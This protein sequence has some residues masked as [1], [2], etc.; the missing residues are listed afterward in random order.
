MESWVSPPK[1]G[2]RRAFF[3]AS[4]S[5][6]GFI[7]YYET[8]FRNQAQ[9]LYIIKGGP[10]TGKSRLMW[11][12]VAAGESAGFAAELYF[13]SSDPTSL[14]AVI[15]THADG[16]SVIFLD[17]T[18]PHTMEACAPG[19]NEQLID[20]GA[21]WS[22]DALLAHHDRIAAL[23]E[24][25]S[26]RYTTAYRYLGAA[27]LCEKNIAD[28]IAPA[29]DRAALARL[30][31][32]LVA[33]AMEKTAAAATLPPKCVCTNGLGM[34][35]WA[36]LP[37]FETLA[38]RTC[39]L[40]SCHGV[41]YA[42]L[43]ALL[44]EGRAKGARMT[45]SC[46]PVYPAYIDGIYFEDS[47]VAFLVDAPQDGT[48]ATEPEAAEQYRRL[49]KLR[50]LIKPA[51]IRGGRSALRAAKRQ[52]DAL[53]SAAEQALLHAATPHF[54]LE[55]IYSGA[56]DFDAKETRSRALAHEVFG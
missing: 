49:V 18:A 23:M 48:D 5:E 55:E 32:R 8:L 44:A 25:K 19:V 17:G 16:R 53:V 28:A 11:D 22:R 38:K 29:L 31:R 30:A 27:G 36:H 9:L 50:R 21:F 10:G 14:D 34:K 47:R 3:A 56:M 20:L 4:N 51:L 52:R 1:Q 24:E 13:C 33:G 15:L 40:E 37:T 45:V 54:A 41:E 39:R 12:M 6:R 43:A 2:E 7:S 35:G 46:H 42:V 26:A